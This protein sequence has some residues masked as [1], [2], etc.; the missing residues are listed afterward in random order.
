MVTTT[1]N[2]QNLITSASDYENVLNEI[3]THFSNT[4]IKR[5]HYSLS[6]KL[7]LQT[8]NQG[9]EIPAEVTAPQSPINFTTN[10]VCETVNHISPQ[11]YIPIIFLQHYTFI[12]QKYSFVPVVPRDYRH[13]KLHIISFS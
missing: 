5:L 11:E 6:S 13:F 1:A 10:F 9:P 3:Q 7:E 2:Q 4:E 8:I 12:S